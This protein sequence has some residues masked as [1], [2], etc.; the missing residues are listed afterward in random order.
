[1]ADAVIDP[2]KAMQYWS[3]AGLPPTASV[4]AGGKVL[5]SCLSA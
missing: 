3:T 4:P 1:M 2:V 5:F